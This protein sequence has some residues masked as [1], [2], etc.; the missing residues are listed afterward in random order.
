MG[1]LERTHSGQGPAFSEVLGAWLVPDGRLLAMA[2]DREGL[3]RWP[4]SEELERA[5][6]ERE[7][8]QRIDLE[9][10]LAALEAKR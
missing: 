5:E 3:R 4:T 6:K 2:N 8:A 7:R 1:L 9:R 10:R